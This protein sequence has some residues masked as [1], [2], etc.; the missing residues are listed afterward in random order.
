MN[1]LSINRLGFKV[2]LDN[3]ETEVINIEANLEIKNGFFSGQDEADMQ[4]KENR[5]GGE[6]DRILCTKE[7]GHH[8]PPTN[9]SEKRYVIHHILALQRFF[10]LGQKR[11]RVCDPNILNLIFNNLSLYFKPPSVK[12]I[13]QQEK[14]LK[15]VFPNAYKAFLH[16]SDGWLAHHDWRII[17]VEELYFAEHIPKKA[18]AF[19]GKKCLVL[20]E[21]MDE[22]CIDYTF[23]IGMDVESGQILVLQKKGQLLFDNFIE[24]MEW[25]YHQ[26]MQYLIE[27]YSWSDE[28]A[29]QLAHQ[30]RVEALSAGQPV[31]MLDPFWKTLSLNVPIT[32]FETCK[33]KTQALLQQD[34][35]LPSFR[36]G[37]KKSLTTSKLG[38][39]P[40][41]ADNE[42]WPTCQ[43]CGLPMQF[44]L[45]IDLS[46][47]KAETGKHPFGEGL[48]QCFHCV[49][50]EK[51]S[52]EAFTVEFRQKRQL[53]R[54]VQDADKQ[55][56]NTQAEPDFAYPLVKRYIT[57]WKR[58][59]EKIVAMEEDKAG[60]TVH[61]YF[62]DPEVD[63]RDN[64][65]DIPKCSTCAQEMLLMIQF[66][67]MKGF[68]WV[69]CDPYIDERGP[70]L[71]IFHCLEHQELVAVMCPFRKGI[72]S[73]HTMVFMDFDQMD[74]DEERDEDWYLRLGR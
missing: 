14:R 37:E 34:V 63:F 35:W 25:A 21:I 51:C 60:G 20:G 3:W 55:A 8:F 56:C 54:I 16:F 49:N 59:K 68:D 9:E 36:K 71:C 39:K 27:D 57:T 22:E 42:T 31:E 73:E 29:L 15:V 40:W 6:I 41:L 44:F 10:T 4:I 26:H 50:P 52:D 19:K 66:T 23:F 13:Q 1:T 24:F 12:I 62:R 43:L 18:K 47:L 30:Q 2:F 64:T 17:G 74:D 33:K 5:Y 69:D 67:T 72:W 70:S 61:G 58:T 32:A 11:S 65:A 45:Q 48:L 7:S 38:G 53:V 46:E 28:E